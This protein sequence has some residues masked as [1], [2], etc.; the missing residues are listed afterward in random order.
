MSFDYFLLNMNFSS[1]MKGDST[2]MFI[3]NAS[4]YDMIQFPAAAC[5]FNTRFHEAELQCIGA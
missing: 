3:K 2:K 1:P 4:P 5:H